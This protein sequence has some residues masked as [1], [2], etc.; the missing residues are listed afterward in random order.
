M[1]NGNG[2][3]YYL[4]IRSTNTR[5]QWQYDNQ[6]FKTKG[7]WKEIKKKNEGGKRGKEKI[8]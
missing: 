8:K 4:H 1:V 2:D 6:S 5:L 3:L 7:S